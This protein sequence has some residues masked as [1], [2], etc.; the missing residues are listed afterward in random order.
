MTKTKRIYICD[1]C[2]AQHLKWQGQCPDCGAWNALSETRDISGRKRL[3]SV[4]A[5]DSHMKRLDQVDVTDV[6]RMGSGLAE[7]D[8]VL[9]GGLVPGSVVLIGGDPGIGKSTLLLSAVANVSESRPACY[10]TGEESLDQIGMRAERLSVS[11]AIVDLMAETNVEVIISQLKLA[12]PSLLVI[13]SIQTL[14]SDQLESAP[15]SVSQ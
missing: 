7:L 10:V 3:P 13:D 1:G 9:G 4:I 14:Y 8:R 2:G 6:E 11:K 15:G 5:S 12:P